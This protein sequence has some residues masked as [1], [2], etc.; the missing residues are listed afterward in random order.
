MILVLDGIDGAGKGVQVAAL[1]ERLAPRFR[2]VEAMH[3][4]MYDSPTGRVIKKMLSGARRLAAFEDLVNPT[5]LGV[6]EALAL[7]SIMLLNRLEFLGKLRNYA[8]DA[9]C[10]IRVTSPSPIGPMSMSV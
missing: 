3:F 8:S 6:D 4:P 1:A 10:T 5:D 9:V 7:Q 2:T